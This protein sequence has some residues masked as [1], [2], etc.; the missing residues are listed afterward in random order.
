MRPVFAR[1]LSWWQ[2]SEIYGLN[3][4]RLKPA[5]GP[6][7]LLPVALGLLLMNVDRRNGLDREPS[8]CAKR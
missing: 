8:R 3:L 1:H 2:R 4:I 7:A 5:K 6:H